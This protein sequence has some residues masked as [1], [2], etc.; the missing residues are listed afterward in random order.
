MRRYKFLSEKDVMEAFNRLQDAF[1]AAK[2]GNEVKKIINCLFTQ[3]EK[4]RLGRRILIAEGLESDLT[5]RELTQLSSVG[6]TTISFVSRQLD[7]FPLGFKLIFNRRI[8]LEKEYEAK[9]YTLRGGSKL[10]HKRKE[11]TGI[12]RSD[13]KR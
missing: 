13:I 12:K 5:I 10:V 4:I 6:Y 7:L 9:K 8:K 11:Y 1:L 3:D 2:D